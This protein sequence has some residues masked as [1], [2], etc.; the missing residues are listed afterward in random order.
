MKITLT[1]RQ[2][3]VISLMERGAT[4]K[5]AAR[6]LGISPSTVKAPK[7]VVAMKLGLANT[8]LINILY[9]LKD[10]QLKFPGEN[11]DRV[12]GKTARGN[13]GATA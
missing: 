10:D 8:R 5:E 9:V 3:E 13:Q 6:K 12:V 2:Q 1:A 4:V 11:F 7:E